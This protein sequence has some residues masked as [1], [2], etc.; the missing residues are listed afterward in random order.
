[1]E[2]YISD[3]LA[4][5]WIVHRLARMHGRVREEFE[6]FC[7]GYS[8]K[9]D[10]PRAL[11]LSRDDIYRELDEIAPWSDTD[12]SRYLILTRIRGCKY[13]YRSRAKAYRDGTLI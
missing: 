1:M 6:F 5:E 12:F 9:S 8:M 11:G 3:S 13:F 7:A 4:A 10:V 2:D